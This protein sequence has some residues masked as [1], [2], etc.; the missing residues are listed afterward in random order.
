MDLGRPHT[1]YDLKHYIRIEG[2]EQSLENVETH[3]IAEISRYLAAAR[4]YLCSVARDPD[5]P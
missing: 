3:P 5:E 2:L 1:R 4:C